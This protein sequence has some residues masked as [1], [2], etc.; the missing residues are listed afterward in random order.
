[1][2]FGIA[3]ESGDNFVGLPDNS[4]ALPVALEVDWMHIYAYKG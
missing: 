4:T 3:V 1:M 2:W